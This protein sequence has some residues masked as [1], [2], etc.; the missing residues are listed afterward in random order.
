MVN[1]AQTRGAHRRKSRAHR[2]E[3]CRPHWPDQAPARP[4]SCPRRAAC[5]GAAQSVAAS[6][7][8]A[9]RTMIR[10]SIIIAGCQTSVS[11][12]DFI[13]ELPQGH[14]GKSGSD[15]VGLVDDIDTRRLGGN[16]AVSHP[17]ICARPLPSAHSGRFYGFKRRHPSLIPAATKT[18]TRRCIDIETERAQSAARAIRCR[19]RGLAIGWQ[20]RATCLRKPGVAGL[21]QR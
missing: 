13:L 2:A 15:T 14:R 8:T 17:P 20:F 5:P 7:E 10:R 21:A 1:F 4:A 9:M 16:L 12:E 3:I 18:A 19:K 6:V 11:L